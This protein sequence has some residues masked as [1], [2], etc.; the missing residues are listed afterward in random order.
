VRRYRK[1][2]LH[3]RPGSSFWH[4]DFWIES[5]RFAK[6]TGESNKDE[7]QK[8]LDDKWADAVAAVKRKKKSGR[9][10]MTFGVAAHRWWDEVG[11]HGKETDL[12]PHI[13]W[14]IEQLGASKPLHK[15]T[16]DD[17]A[18]LVGLRRKVLVHAAS[19]ESGAAMARKISPRTVNRTVTMLVRRIVRRAADLW[20]VD[21]PNMPKWSDYLIEEKRKLP[22]VLGFDEEDQME[23]TERPELTVARKFALMSG[24]RLD[25]V[26]SL[27]KFN[28]D[29]LHQKI[30]LIQ[31]GDQPRE[32]A[33]TPLME[34]L[35]R[36]LWDHHETAIFTFVA[37]RTR[38]CPKTG[39]MFVRGERYPL[40]YWGLTTARRR[41]WKKAGVAAN[42]HDLRR[43]AA[44]RIRD[45][46]GDGVEGAQDLLGH[47]D[48][49]TTMG[50]IGETIDLDRQR[51]TMIRRD[52]IEAEM[53][54]N[55]HKKSHTTTPA[56]S[57]VLKDK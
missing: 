57:N 5:N 14:L 10:P 49:K 41:D 32:L 47:S 17:I 52:Q 53:R 21:V 7:A 29:F 6:S 39:T 19:D 54:E 15:I 55:S 33:I 23:A 8:V 9:T 27:T 24:L 12:V 16:G 43:T 3:R 30:N 13:N 40:T 26:V 2:E 25:E 31:K 37:K 51:A 28:V 56:P 50:Y 35:L 34:A 46:G 42:W 22:R 11:Q 20:N 18:R 38:R 1:P 44:R 4:Y 48:R 45:Y 36:S